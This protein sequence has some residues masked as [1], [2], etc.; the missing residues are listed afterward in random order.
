[1]FTRCPHKWR[2]G[3]V[4][5]TYRILTLQSYRLGREE[6]RMLAFLLGV[7]LGAIIA[8]LGP[9][10]LPQQFRNAFVDSALR[11]IGVLAI[12][13]AI[14]STSFV[15]VPDGYLG[16]LFRVYGGG[17]LP[18]GRPL[19]PP[20]AKRPQAQNPTPRLPSLVPVTPPCS[21]HIPPT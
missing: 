8:F 13:F 11:I 17:A 9:S 21:A 10:L 19:P 14:A 7:V 18:Q 1:M 2:A 12:L 15:R 6:L 4:T 16:Q 20:G 3:E 5:C